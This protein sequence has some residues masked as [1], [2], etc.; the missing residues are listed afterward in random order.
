MCCF[1][2]TPHAPVVGVHTN[3]WARPL[4]ATALGTLVGA[5][6]GVSYFGILGLLVGPLALSYFFEILRMY[7]QEFVT[8][9]TGSGFTQELAVPPPAAMAP[10]PP[11]SPP[12]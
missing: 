12:V 8:E 6:A 10:T 3:A 5:V 4:A 11:V 7:R 9:G 1:V 2:C